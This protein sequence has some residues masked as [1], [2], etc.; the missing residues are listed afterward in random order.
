[1]NMPEDNVYSRVSIDSA[2]NRE[3]VMDL[4]PNGQESETKLKQSERQIVAK[5]K[6]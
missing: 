1:M 2:K 4:D 5:L 3:S 6:N